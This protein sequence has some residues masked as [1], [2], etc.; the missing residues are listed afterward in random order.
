MADC[1]QYGYV[2]IE[3]IFSK[4]ID[5]G[6]V[7]PTSRLTSVN[8]VRIVESRKCFAIRGTC[9]SKYG[10]NLEKDLSPLEKKHTDIE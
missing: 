8:M 10:V 9:Q 6:T 3:I 7:G 1:S 5:E 4:K 2:S